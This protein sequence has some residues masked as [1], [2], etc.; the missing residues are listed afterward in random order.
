MAFLVES[1]RR[2]LGAGAPQGAWK[3]ARRQTVE[4]NVS[5][6]ANTPVSATTPATITVDPKVGAVSQF[7]IPKNNRFVLVDAYIKSTADIGVD[8]IARLKR[9]FFIDH[10]VT[11]PVSTLYVGNPSR[12]T[13]TPKAW[14]E[15]DTISV[16]FNN[17]EAV[18]TATTV[19]FYLVFDVFER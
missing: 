19:K 18:A 6:P 10:V 5:I 2:G 4:V 11:P 13:V 16:E 7:T 15:G 14:E 9:N 8:G 1:L 12:P 3:L 17:L